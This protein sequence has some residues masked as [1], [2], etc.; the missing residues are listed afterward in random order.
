MKVSVNNSNHDGVFRIFMWTFPESCATTVTQVTQ[1]ATNKSSCNHWHNPQGGEPIST[2]HT[3]WQEVTTQFLL[4]IS[5]SG[6]SSAA[7]P[8]IMTNLKWR[9]NRWSFL[10]KPVDCTYDFTMDYQVRLKH[11]TNLYGCVPTGDPNIELKVAASLAW[12]WIDHSFPGRPG[13]ALAWPLFLHL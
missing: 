7:K 6:R 10:D 1:S 11:R 3:H 9:L 4:P 12:Y 2:C 5:S 13:L 8:T